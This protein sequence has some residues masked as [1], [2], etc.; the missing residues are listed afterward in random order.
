MCSDVLSQAE[1][2]Q[3]RKDLAGL[4]ALALDLMHDFLMPN[5]SPP[6]ACGVLLVLGRGP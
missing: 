2:L 1:P 4:L 6:S 3:R 5:L